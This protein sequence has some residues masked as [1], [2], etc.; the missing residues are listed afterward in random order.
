[1]FTVM[2]VTTHNLLTTKDLADDI[3]AF[4]SSSSCCSST[5][6]ASTNV[7]WE[8]KTCTALLNKGQA[9]E[10][11]W[12]QHGA[13]RLKHVVQCRKRVRQNVPGLG[14]GV[15]DLDGGVGR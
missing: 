2:N 10:C 5:V 7:D 6:H 9:A 12:I 1:M 3:P 13:A 11:I 14:I 15:K 4:R 8:V